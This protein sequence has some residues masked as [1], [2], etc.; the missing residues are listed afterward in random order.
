MLKKQ[1]TIT[2]PYVLL[3]CKLVHSKT[4]ELHHYNENFCSKQSLMAQLRFDK[5]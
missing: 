5:I 2:S 4:K 1:N 3:M